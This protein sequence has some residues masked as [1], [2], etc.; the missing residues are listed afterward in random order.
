MAYIVWF[1]KLIPSFLVEIFAKIMSPI[2]ALF[3]DEDGWL[4]NWLS[5][6]RTPDNS[7]DGDSAHRARWPKNG[8]F[9]TWMRRTAWLFRN[10]AYGFNIKIGF[11]YKDGDVRI[12]QGNT[13]AGDR[14]GVSGVVHY[15]VYRNNK[16]VAFQDYLAYHYK[17]FGTWRCVR[18][19]FGYKIWGEPTSKVYGQHWLYFNPFKGS[20]RNDH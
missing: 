15:R 10:S 14:S 4:P 1:L 9:W 11:K 8:K 16:L 18:M 2:L 3:C 19:G 12:A 17:V 5:W 13:E 6:F 20:G 7:C